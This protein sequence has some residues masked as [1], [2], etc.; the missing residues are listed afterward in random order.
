MMESNGYYVGMESE[1]GVEEAKKALDA[2]PELSSA[3]S[4]SGAYPYWFSVSVSLW[5]GLLVSTVGE[6][7]WVLVFV[8]G[9]VVYQFWRRAYCKAWAN[10]VKTFKELRTVILF[11]IPVSG[12][13]LLSYIVRTHYGNTW[14]PVIAGMVVGLSLYFLCEKTY[15]S[16]R[17]YQVGERNV[18]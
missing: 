8:A 11:A 18:R 9:L 3:G 1:K 7:I 16:V 6:A 5:A 15:A 12:L 10:E 17:K 13:F 4:R 2:V 14:I